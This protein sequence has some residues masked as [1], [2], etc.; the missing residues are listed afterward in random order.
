MQNRIEKFRQSSIDFKKPGNLSENLRTLMSSNYPKVQ[1]FLLKLFTRFLFTNA[2][3]AVSGIL[4]FFL[5]TSGVI[6]KNVKRPGFYALTFYIFI[7]NSRSKQNKNP[8]QIF[9]D[10]GK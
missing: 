1:Y 4:L 7:N 5:F 10:V 2:C 6:K 9:V 3:K 8:R